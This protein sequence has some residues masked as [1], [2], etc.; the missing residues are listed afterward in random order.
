MTYCNFD[1]VREVNKAFCGFLD[2]TE[3]LQ[4]QVHES[5]VGVATGNWGCGI[6]GGDAQLKSMIQWVSASQVRLTQLHI[7][8]CG[9]I[10][11]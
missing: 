7:T 1:F 5:N 10:C 6:F 11:T 8:L 3:Y 9:F 4:Q 2:H